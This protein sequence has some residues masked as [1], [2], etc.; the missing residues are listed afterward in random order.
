MYLEV[1]VCTREYTNSPDL[2]VDDKNI[3]KLF[4]VT[5]RNFVMT[6]REQVCL[7]SMYHFRS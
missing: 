2:A 4:G 1:D 6:L 5:G 7:G 3:K